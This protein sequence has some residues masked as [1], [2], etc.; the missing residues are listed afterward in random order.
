VIK[1]FAIVSYSIALLFDCNKL[2]FFFESAS[3]KINDEKILSQIHKKLILSDSIVMSKTDLCVRLK[4]VSAST[5]IRDRAFNN[6][7]NDK[8]LVIGDWFS[9]KSIKGIVN[10]TGY[11]KGFP[12]NDFQSQME[13]AGKLAKYG[14]DYID[15][16]KSFRKD[17]VGALPRT[18]DTSDIKQSK[19]LYSQALMDKILSNNFLKERLVIDPSA[20]IH[21]SN[22]K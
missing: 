2:L 1:S 11:L 3:T 19:W 10:F 22:S 20:V 16:E 5:Q 12:E 6:L 18:L 8:L 15:F 21:S 14:L 17:K 4:H 7:V 9:S 13:F